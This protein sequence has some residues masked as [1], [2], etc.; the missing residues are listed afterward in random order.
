MSEMNFIGFFTHKKCNWLRQQERDVVFDDVK[1][2]DRV[3]GGAW[4][5]GDLCGE[6]GKGGVEL[7][8]KA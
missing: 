6:G 4:G 5:G 7:K 8:G 1:R 2:T 3:Q